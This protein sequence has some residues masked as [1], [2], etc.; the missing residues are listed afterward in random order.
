[1]IIYLD[2]HTKNVCPTLVD[3]QKASPRVQRSAFGIPSLAVVQEILILLSNEE[4]Q[5][6]Y[7]ILNLF[8]DQWM[9][10]YFRESF[11]TSLQL[12]SLLVVEDS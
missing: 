5:I 6:W 4:G 8:W 10:G 11:G 9:Q 3:P 12:E 2:M 1:M 7:V